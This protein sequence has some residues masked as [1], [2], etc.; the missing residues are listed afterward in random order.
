MPFNISNVI[1]WVN[2]VRGVLTSD[3]I[4]GGVDGVHNFAATDLTRRTNWLKQR[5][6]TLYQQ[7]FV[8]IDG[9]KALLPDETRTAFYFSKTF[10]NG[11]AQCC[12]VVKVSTGPSAGTESYLLTFIPPSAAGATGLELEYK[13]NASPVWTPAFSMPLV[14]YYGFT[15]VS[16]QTYQ[17]RIK[18]VGGA[19]DGRYSATFSIST[20][21]ETGFTAANLPPIA[22]VA[23]GAGYFFS[24]QEAHPYWMGRVFANGS[25]RIVA[26]HEE[27]ASLSIKPGRDGVW[28]IKDSGVWRMVG[29]NPRAEVGQAAFFAGPKIPRGW[30]LATGVGVN[31]TNAADLFDALGTIYGAPDASSF[32]IPDLR[33]EFLRGL[34]LERRAD[35]NAGRTLGSNQEDEFKSHFHRMFKIN[36]QTGTAS[37]GFFA[38]DDHGTDGSENTE[39]TG[40]LETRPRNVAM[41]ACI[42][43]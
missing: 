12:T 20:L 14:T 26:D 31:R 6:D 16:A 4:E 28:L 8:K 30:M 37:Q 23:N 32:R 39:E 35:A 7:P 27:L 36:R 13:I 33:G 40:G 17:F 24:N 15:G 43:F 2:N 3:Q 42:K 21:L 38:M 10:D 18:T 11:I 1:E 29:P 19:N 5:V 9:T 34:D 41:L 25:D 22:D